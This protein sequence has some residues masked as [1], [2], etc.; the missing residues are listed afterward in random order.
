MYL[1]HARMTFRGTMPGGEQFATTLN[2]AKGINLAFSE[3]EIEA[4]ADAVGPLW[5]TFHA[6][7][8]AQLSALVGFARVDT[9][10]IGTDGKATAQG[11]FTPITPVV[12]SGGVSL[13]NQ[14]TM[15]MSLRTGRPGRAFRGRMYLP[16][17]A[18]GDGLGAD[19]RVQIGRV[20]D[21]ADQFKV[22]VDAVNTLTVDGAD[23]RAVV[24]SGVG[25]GANTLIT[26][27]SAGRVIDTQRRRRNE[28]VEEP[29]V[30]PVVN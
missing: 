20:E 10:A 15:V 27:I 8:N 18:I 12:G 1:P 21:L 9:Y 14:C 28:L 29:Y 11:T 13:P 6:S 24:A 2:V 5:G 30:V 22:F 25:L 26:T 4:L 16:T 19:G 3:S 17:L 7:V 23:V